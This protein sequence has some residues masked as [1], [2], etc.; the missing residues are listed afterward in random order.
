MRELA[1]KNK[2]ESQK[3]RGG[4]FKWFVETKNELKKVTWPTK[5]QTFNNTV[6]VFATIILLG[7]LVWVFDAGL[8]NLV[9]NFVIK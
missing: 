2:A 1:N 3:K 8:M 9:N 5:N 7:G 4:F 6:I